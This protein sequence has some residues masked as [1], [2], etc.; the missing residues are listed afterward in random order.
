VLNKWAGGLFVNPINAHRGNIDGDRVRIIIK[1]ERFLIKKMVNCRII[2]IFATG[3]N[4]MRVKL[5]DV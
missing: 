4:L 1:R 3:I 2:T 5:I